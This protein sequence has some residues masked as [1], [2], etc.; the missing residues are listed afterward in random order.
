V[1]DGSQADAGGGDGSG[2]N[3]NSA[4]TGTGGNGGSAN[5]GSGNGG[6]GGTSGGGTS[7]G[8]TGG[9]TG[10]P[11][12]DDAP[13]DGCVPSC[14]PLPE[15]F[16]E[17]DS[18]VAEPPFAGTVWFSPDIITDA[19]PTAFVKLT[20]KG[21]GSRTMFD[22][23]TN[24][25][26]TYDAHLF[27]AGF[28]TSVVVEMQVN[29]EFTAEEAESQAEI[30]AT[31]IGRL[32]AFLFTD[33]EAVWIHKGEELFGG[34]NNSLLIH[35]DQAPNYIADGV[36]EETLLHEAVH[37]SVDSY[38]AEDS[39]WMLAQSS[40]GVALSTYAQDNPTREDLSET[41]G[42]Y[43]AVRFRAAR[44]DAET[45]TTVEGTIPN[46]LEYLDCLGLS[47]ALVP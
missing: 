8:G 28:G 27:D 47:M 46:R 33:I 45:I 13:E 18:P 3:G 5:G 26:E 39:N 11:S 29:P 15:S 40:D 42:P 12:C 1:A 2:G 25:F 37:T 24:A 38:H 43:L 31:V 21:T 35:T 4:G 22:R 19:D 32:P 30:F 17:V 23:R 44:L 7:S 34:G 16:V 6:D 36:L 9:N 14:Q 41:I 10:A 20:A